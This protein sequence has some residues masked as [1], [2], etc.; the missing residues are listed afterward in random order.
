MSDHDDQASPDRP[1][2]ITLTLPAKAELVSLARLTAAAVG[3]RAG[4]DVEEIEDLRLA[5]DELVVSFEPVH[6]GGTLQLRYSHDGATL[7]I[8]CTIEPGATAHP[9][10]GIAGGE[11]WGVERDLSQQILAAL[12][13][14]CGQ[15]IRDGQPCVWFRKHRATA[16]T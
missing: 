8:E 7:T 5:V 15:D 9:T 12:V 3:S 14:E 10:D 1:E 13:D 11:L 6:A 2:V 16:A 4:F